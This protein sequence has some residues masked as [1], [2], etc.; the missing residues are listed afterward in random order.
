MTVLSCIDRPALY[1]WA[2]ELVRKRP[3]RIPGWVPR[4]VVFL[5]E[6]TLK[7]NREVRRP[8]GT[9]FVIA[10]PVK[11]GSTTIYHRYLVTAMHVVRKLEG[12]EHYVRA[13][14]TDGFSKELVVKSDV[15]WWR[16]PTEEDLIDAAVL[17]FESV[18]GDWRD[19]EITPIEKAY[20][21]SNVD[22]I[23]EYYIDA[24]DEVYCTGLFSL[25]AGESRN[26]PITRAGAIAM[27]P[28]D[29]INVDLGNGPV[30]IE[31]YLVELRS[32][33]GLS[34][35]PVF[36]RA[37]IGFDV[38]ARSLSGKRRDLEVHVPGDFYLLGLM[39]GHW[40]I[41]KKRKNSNN[42]TPVEKNEDSINLGIGVV[43]PARKILEIINHP[44]LITMRELTKEQRENEGTTI[45]DIAADDDLSLCLQKR[46]S[47]RN[48][49]R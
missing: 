19:V 41:D 43:V 18:E 32:I 7:G 44:E 16:H 39:H 23:G 1:T 13:N 6:R 27:M 47:K 17:P 36:V 4:S 10:I 28:K 9:A 45:L 46:R 42:I 35:S 40:E 8:C 14:T 22:S 5:Y 3:M 38:N 20:M 30:D 25:L 31:G 2:D 15:N 11:S 29:K 48:P 12:K 37:S 24:G 49:R 34:G 21:L 33:G 26:L